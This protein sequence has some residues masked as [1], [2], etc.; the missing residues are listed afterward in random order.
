VSDVGLHGLRGHERALGDPSIGEAFGEE[1]EDLALSVGELGEGIVGPRAGDEVL[2]QRRVDD[3]LAG[4]Y[5]VDGG[6]ERRVGE[7]RSTALRAGVTIAL[8]PGDQRGPSR[9]KGSTWCSWVPSGL[10]V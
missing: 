8:P 6:G 1:G 9:P 4:V 3:G 10:T 5:P 2:D 7:E